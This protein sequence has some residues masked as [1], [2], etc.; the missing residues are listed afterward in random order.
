M[1]GDKWFGKNPLLLPVSCLIHRLR[2]ATAYSILH[3]AGLTL[4]WYNA[5]FGHFL[6]VR[7]KNS[8]QIRKGKEVR[9]MVYL[10]YV[11]FEQEEGEGRGWHGTEYMPDCLY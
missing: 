9:K 4:V 5:E 7:S 6:F 1:A 2:V 10:P 3:L 8:L 11:R